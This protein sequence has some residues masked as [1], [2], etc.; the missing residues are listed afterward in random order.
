ML[1]CTTRPGGKQR[2]TATHPADHVALAVETPRLKT[3]SS[4]DCPKK[5][6]LCFSL[7][8]GLFVSYSPLC[9]YHTTSRGGSTRPY[10]PPPPHSFSCLR[11]YQRESGAKAIC[12]AQ[13]LNRPPVRT[14]LDLPD[15]SDVEKRS[16]STSCL[17]TYEYSNAEA[18]IL[19]LGTR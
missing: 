6:P 9:A 7:S 12:L 2:P 5:R 10:S 11:G 16:S 8:L 13:R 18:V 3:A 4:L 14:S 15:F 17:F 1:W 19:R